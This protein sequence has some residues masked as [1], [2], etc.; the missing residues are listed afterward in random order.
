MKRK[1]LSHKFLATVLACMCLGPLAVS[2][3]NDDLGCIE[4]RPGYVEG[5]DVWLKIS[6]KQQSAVGHQTADSRAGNLVD[7]DGHPDEIATE[8]E[9]HIND[10]D[11]TLVLFDQNRYAIKTLTSSDFI[12]STVNGSNNSQYTISAKI[13]KAYFDLAGNGLSVLAIANTKGVNRPDLA[14]DS[15]NN[16]LFM[17]SIT[18]IGDML[19]GYG[20]DGLDSESQIWVPDIE[21]GRHIPM[22]GLEHMTLDMAALDNATTPEN[23][24][25]FNDITMQ[26]AMAKIRVLDGIVFQDKL[27]APTHIESVSFC[28][29]T[30]FGAYM[31]AISQATAWANGT[32]VIETATKPNPISSWH[33]ATMNFPTVKG[34]FY[35]VDESKDYTSFVCYTPELAVQGVKSIASA[36]PYLL[37]VTV[38]DNGVRQNH[39][40]YLDEV[41][42]QNDMVRNHIYQFI[43]TKTEQANISINYTVCE[44][45]SAV[46]GDITFN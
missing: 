17:K 33:D 43:V 28:R 23:A 5:N 4:D 20:F 13:N 45:K 12:L 40:V 38:S 16:S 7:P 39:T 34:S 18:Q 25:K 14:T 31:P 10:Q 19:K 1:Q 27:P 21:K 6:V 42:P 15:Y 36:R 44:W 46:S 37:I 22:A 29:G 8:A 2:C 35:N 9:N 26:R 11:F 24:Y 32:A 41:M 3:V 30:K